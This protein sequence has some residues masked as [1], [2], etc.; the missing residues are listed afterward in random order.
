MTIRVSQ[1]RFAFTLIEVLVV[2]AIIA[3]LIAMLVPAVQKVREAAARTQCTNNLKQMGLACH[4]HHDALKAFPAAGLAPGANRTLIGSIPATYETQAWGWCYQILPYIDQTPLWSL[5][6]GAEGYIIETPMPFLY[7]PTRG[8][9][10][11]VQN[12][13]VSDYAGNG[14]SW[15]I[16]NTETLEDNSLD[17]VFVPAPSPTGCN[18]ITMQSIT[19][20]ASNTLLIGEKWLYYQWYN[21][22]TTGGGSCIDDQGWCNGWD[23]DS[24]CFSGTNSTISGYTTAYPY[25][26]TL[27]YV[28]PVQDR[29]SAWSCGFVFGSAHAGS[30]GCLLCDGTVRLVAYTINPAT[31][32]ALCTRNDGQPIDLDSF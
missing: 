19:D 21:N 13:A 1:R 5:P 29:T 15:G 11:V 4:A 17:G 8:R 18:R 32:H 2:I 20:G 27:Y 26:G 24:I 3:I 22:R 25:G 16:W 14:G 7:C 9:E 28:P 12:I 31:F 10:T 30:F 23:N 6:D